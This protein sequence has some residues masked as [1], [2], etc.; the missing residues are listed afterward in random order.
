MTL[1]NVAPGVYVRQVAVTERVRYPA[2]ILDEDL[3]LLITLTTVK[4]HVS[5][6][7][8]ALG[9]MTSQHQLTDVDTDHA[10]TALT[11]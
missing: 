9:R 5:P 3:V 10:H 6:V 8:E 4:I 2:A 1:V 7:L 11:V